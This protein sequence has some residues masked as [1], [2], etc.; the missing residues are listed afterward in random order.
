MIVYMAVFVVVVGC[1]TATFFECWDG[2]KAL[3]R[4]A[5]EVA[6]V[7]DIGE[8]WRAD[9]RRASGPVQLGAKD[10]G[11]QFRIPAARAEI[12][13][14]FAD[15]EIH[16]QAGSTAPN[17]LWL[18]NV[19]SSQMQSDPRGNVAAWRWELELKSSRKEPR[20]RPLFTFESAAGTVANP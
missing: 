17:T 5:D 12:T 8:Q 15:G 13:Y 1:A 7:L 9:L 18:G 10:G 6:R 4:N 16:R 2:A 11:E 19:K 14:T 3:R 20:L